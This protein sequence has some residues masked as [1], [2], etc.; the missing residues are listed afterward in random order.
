MLVEPGDLLDVHEQA[1]RDAQVRKRIARETRGETLVI[2][3]LTQ[4]QRN[5]GVPDCLGTGYVHPPEEA[6]RPG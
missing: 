4:R 6:R 2:H 3:H 1:V 5:A